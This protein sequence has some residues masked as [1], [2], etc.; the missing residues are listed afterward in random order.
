MTI[1]F[2]AETA[3]HNARIEVL[4]ARNDVLDQILNALNESGHTGSYNLL[5]EK[6]QVFKHLSVKYQGKMLWRKLNYICYSTSCCT[7]KT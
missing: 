5:L 1:C 2:Q 4:K 7:Q 3:A 6:F